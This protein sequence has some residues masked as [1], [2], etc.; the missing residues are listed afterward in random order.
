MKDRA[1]KQRNI[2]FRKVAL[3]FMLVTS[4]P[5]FLSVGMFDWYTVRE[6]RSTLTDSRRSTLAIYRAQLE[7]TF[8]A[9]EIY[10]ADI[11]ANDGDFQ[12][13]VY[14]KSRMEAY[15]SSYELSKRCSVMLYTYPLIGGFFTY[16]SPYD[17]YRI[18]YRGSYRQ[19]DLMAVRAAVIQAGDSDLAVEKWIPLTFFDRTVFLYLQTLHHTVAAVM[20][21]PTQQVFQGLEPQDR[22]FYTDREGEPYTPRYGFETAVPVSEGAGEFRSS[23]GE[24]YDLT[25]LPLS[26]VEGCIFY[27][28]PATGF[29]E[30]L[31]V[32]QRVLLL[33]TFLLIACIPCGWLVL[34]NFL[35]E[36]MTRLA[37]ATQEIQKGDTEIRVAEDSDVKEANEIARTVNIMMDTI[38][39]Q[40]I[41]SYEQQLELQRAQLQYLQIQIRPHFF[42]N[43]L[44]V[45][46]SLAGEKKLPEL[47]EVTLA[48]SD[49]LRGI[50]KNSVRLIPLSTEI[51]SVES[52]VRIHQLGAGLPPELEVE[53]GP[54]AVRIPVPPISILTFVENSIK[55]SRRLDAPLRIH[56]AAQRLCTED[57]SYLNVT[58][59]DNGGGFSQDVLRELNYPKDQ[60]YSEQHIGIANIR[61]RLK[62]LYEGRASLSFRNL[63]D[64]ACIE[65]FLPIDETTEGGGQDDGPAG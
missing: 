62:F 25:L 15:S 63:T 47:Q 8:Q 24:R 60:L 35:L 29:L 65:L 59:R 21:D 22:I 58:I 31:G 36:P 7:D 4:V 54:D 64:G 28:S 27:A 18:T 37:K 44:N 40:K 55:H 61:Y 46:Y 3:L 39:Q 45:I 33:F 19:E 56:I 26:T 10:L 6:Q 5:L 1:V 16:S 57:G 2:P 43:C 53:I 48:L 14:A 30:F 11:V 51:S 34:R 12:R 38:R 13:I 20:V 32:A 9:S 50:F 42:L 41:E 23:D 52:Y 49:Y 17:C